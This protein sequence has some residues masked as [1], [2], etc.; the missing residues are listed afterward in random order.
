EI[1]NFFI[2]RLREVAVPHADRVERLR[3]AGAD[4]FIRHILKVRTGLRCSDGDRDDDALRVLLAQRRYCGPH[5]GT[6]GQTVI[7]ENDRLAA[8]IG[9]G[10]VAAIA[11]LTPL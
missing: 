1:T 3:C 6:R 8:H 4:G 5:G 7:H 2:R 10:A 11:A 9:W